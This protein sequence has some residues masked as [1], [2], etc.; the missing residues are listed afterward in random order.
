[1]L[2]TRILAAATATLLALGMA[3]GGASA[4]TAA[5]PQEDT[6]VWVCKY[7]GTPGVNEQYKGGKNPIDVS[8]S[9]IDTTTPY[10]PET[11]LGFDLETGTGYFADGQSRSYSIGYTSSFP[12]DPDFTNCPRPLLPI[13]GY[14]VTVVPRRVV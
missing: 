5:P 9:T 12:E 4:A 7:S 3:A 8:I 10:D 11:G 14:D 6:K 2:R 1:M 13:P